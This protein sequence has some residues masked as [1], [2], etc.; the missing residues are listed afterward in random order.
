MKKKVFIILLLIP[1]SLSWVFLNSFNYLP[2]TLKSGEL[3]LNPMSADIRNTTQW[4]KN[5][6]FDSAGEFWNPSFTGDLS[7]VNAS[8]HS[9]E[10]HFEILGDKKTYSLIADPPLA[11]NWHERNNPYFPTRPD[12]YEITSAG[13]RVSHEFDDV[14]AV[15]NPSI[16]W[17]Q[18]ISMKVDMSDYFIKS[19]SIQAIV[20]ATVDENLDRF[21]DYIHGYFAR[22]TPND[23]IDTYSV[24]DYVRF[25]VS[26]SD[27]DKNKIYEIAYFQTS[28][29]GIGNPPGKDYLYDTY[30]VSVPQEVLVFYLESV[31]DTDNSN[32]TISLGINLHIED[33]LAS[34]W[35]LDTFDELIIKY[36]N[37]TFTYEKKIDQYTSISWSQ[38]GSQIRGDNIKILDASLNFKYK[39][40]INWSET[41]SPNSEL[42]ILINNNEL[43]KHIKLKDIEI[44]FQNL[45]LGADDIKSY[46][47]T[48]INFTFSIMIFLADTFALNQI[49]DFSIDDV[50]LT[51]SYVKF[52][53][54]S[55]PYSLIFIILIILL[56][57][58]AL[59][60]SL[61]LR[62][63]ILIPR[64]LKKRTALLSRTQKF[65]DA[66][67]IQG[68]LM[69]HNPSGLPLFSRNYSNLMEGNKAIFSGFLQAI[70]I[71]GEEVIRKDYVK[72]KGI[73]TNLVDGLHNVLEL[74]F[75]H[76]YCL[77]S[78]IEELRT[79]LILNS[80]AS[81]RIKRQLLNFGLNVYAKYSEILKD[82]NHET[83]I[84]QVGVPP[85]LDNFFN[86][87]Y[88]V[89]YKLNVEK[90]DLENIKKE[91]K[92]SKIE[93][94]ILNEILSI[95]EEDHIFKL[96]SLLNK[97]NYRNEDLV[98]NTI[99]ILINK[100]LLIPAD[101][102]E[103]MI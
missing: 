17:E 73:Q 55:F 84:F 29:L 36:V 24:G 31:L 72:S 58:I 33:N 57:V 41:L 53:N 38:K 43:E 7:D 88:K 25:F 6:N 93:Y 87:N 51:I 44:P 32:F 45:S 34:Y 27:L 9:G 62:S 52:S 90:S 79:V 13:C 19:A 28:Q 95:S 81:K 37:F 26:I 20:N 102:I 54:E 70:S 21:Y 89:F 60:T 15:Q 14:T 71:V 47:L 82:W 49:M 67:N 64:K 91:L 16:L 83:N 75:K 48:N 46:I 50:Y 65:K 56:L 35:D 86:M 78:D 99:E 98:I 85:L 5:P 96:I 101:S 11:M 97:I 4:L 66:E 3:N 23:V 39:V 40:N 76:F 69:V 12:L 59:L 80:K 94:R 2:Y 92:L 61:S 1:L 10:A 42:R 8:I 22:T 103:I 18:N 30:M 74:D 100:K 77:I 63:Y 68:I